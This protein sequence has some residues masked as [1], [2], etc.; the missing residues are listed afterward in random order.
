MSLQHGLSGQIKSSLSKGDFN[1]VF[2]I[3]T[4]LGACAGGIVRSQRKLLDVS[5]I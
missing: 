2:Q 3:V 5:R 4:I 1:G